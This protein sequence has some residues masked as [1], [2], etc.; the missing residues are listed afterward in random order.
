MEAARPL[1]RHDHEIGAGSPPP[2][3]QNA[4]EVARIE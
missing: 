3:T 2:E 4:L 1:Q